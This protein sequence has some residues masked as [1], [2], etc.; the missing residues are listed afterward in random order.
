[1]VAPAMAEYVTDAG[2][3]LLVVYE[4]EATTAATGGPAATEGPVDNDD[5]KPAAGVT[6]AA[7]AALEAGSEMKESGEAGGVGVVAPASLVPTDVGVDGA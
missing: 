1:M 4:A 7:A 5:E 3:L 2:L 6:T